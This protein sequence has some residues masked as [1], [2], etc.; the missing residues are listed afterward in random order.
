LVTFWASCKKGPVQ[1]IV[2]MAHMDTVFRMDTP[3]SVKRDG[4]ITAA[5]GVCDTR[6]LVL[7]CALGFDLLR[8]LTCRTRCPHRERRGRGLGVL[9]GFFFFF[10]VVFWGF[11][12]Y[13]YVCN[14][15]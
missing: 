8:N 6:P 10:F 5:P 13:R 15:S 7:Q 11:F 4:N 9:K 14:T 3:I 12:F 1:V 2:S